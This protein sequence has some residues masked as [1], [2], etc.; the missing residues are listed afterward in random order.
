[1]AFTVAVLAAVGAWAAPAVGSPSS[2]GIAYV[3]GGARGQ[4]SV[5]VTDGS[6]ANAHRLA[7]GDA[8][9]LSPDGQTVAVSDLGSTGPALSLYPSGGAASGGAATG[10]FNLA[11]ASAAPLA[12]SPDSRY[13]AVALTGV[14]LPSLSGYGLAII[15]TETGTERMVAT[16][17][18]YGASFAPGASD[19]LV[20]GRAS[21]LSGSAATN[22]YTAA[23]DATTTTRITTDGRSADPVWGARGIAFDHERFRKGYAPLDEIWLMQP[24]GTGRR[25]ITH[26]HVG[27]LV[28]GLAPLAFSADGTRLAAEFEGEDTSI[29]Y[30]VS[31][32]TGHATQ[33][34]VGSQS[35]SA[36]GISSNGRS[37]LI[38]V[39]GF[40]RPSDKAKIETIPFSGGRPTLLIAHG[41]FPSWNL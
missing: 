35:V 18:I 17:L 22:I 9:L 32:L 6:G 24:N 40:E 2:A 14:N 29:G 33:L 19:T 34:K 37:V 7:P 11:Q 36:W 3:L 31:I 27:P 15:D 1:M 39:G 26:T 30:S 23:S 13:L 21:S 38:S 28:S 4:P 12:W 5:W 8:A 25:Q 16:G 10:Y 41:D 20:Y